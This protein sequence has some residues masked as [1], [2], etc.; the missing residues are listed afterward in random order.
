MLRLD[1]TGLDQMTS[2]STTSG[3]RVLLSRLCKKPQNTI[4]SL[5]DDVCLCAIEQLD[6][7]VFCGFLQSPESKTLEPEVTDR[8]R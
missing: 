8:D 3:S 4:S 5:F 6:Q 2:G 7:M 1:D